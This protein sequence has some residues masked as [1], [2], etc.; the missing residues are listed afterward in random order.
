MLLCLGIAYDSFYATVVDVSRCNR[1]I[2][3]QKA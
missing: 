2:M 1:D 3:A